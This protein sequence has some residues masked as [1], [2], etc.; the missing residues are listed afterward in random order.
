M[1]I[2]RAGKL[3]ADAFVW[4]EGERLCRR[5][6]PR[7]IHLDWVYSHLLLLL[8]LEWLSYALSHCRGG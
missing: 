5:N 3:L 4:C 8:L 1:R 6:L 2:A 7:I